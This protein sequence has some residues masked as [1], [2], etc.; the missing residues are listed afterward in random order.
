METSWKK[1]EI[2]FRIGFLSKLLTV[3][4]LFSSN[5]IAR[6]DCQK[7]FSEQVPN[8]NVAFDQVTSIW[9]D[10]HLTLVS[11]EVHPT[12]DYQSIGP[13]HQGNYRVFTHQIFSA[14]LFNVEVLD[15]TNILDHPITDNKFSSQ[16]YSKKAIKNGRHR[17]AQ[18][19]NEILDFV[20]PLYKERRGWSEE[21]ITHLRRKAHE[22]IDHTRYIVVRDKSGN[23]VATLGLSR[24]TYG[25]VK[26][27]NKITQ[28][29]EELTGPFGRRFSD[30]NYQGLYDN[31]YGVGYALPGLWGKPIPLL[32]METLFSEKAFLPRPS[33][34]EDL[35]PDLQQQFGAANTILKQRELFLRTDYRGTE[36]F[37]WK[38]P[39]GAEPDLDKLIEFSVG[40]IFEP[41][42]FAIA[43]DKELRQFAHK[44]ILL[45]LFAMIFSGRGSPIDEMQNQYLYT[46]NDEAGIAL[47]RRFGFE[48]L[49]NVKSQIVD[50]TR[51]FVLGLSPR[52]LSNFLLNHKNISEDEARNILESLQA[53]FS[54]SEPSNSELP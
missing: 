14:E 27:H 9:N 19:L 5:A 45:Q 28:K 11:R 3:S 30:D 37:I 48:K 39:K 23:I 26:F 29:V 18:L 12:V 15:S 34:R 44:E 33:T 20:L 31:T 40:Q 47:Y 8:F 22:S 7:L 46:Y 32:P 21:F 50:G 2:H 42:K 43:K 24:A 13:L 41:T 10:S 16:K 36:K 49:D 38:W 1:S 54:R 25:K 53:D 6:F 17:Q 52:R 4:L 51:W 35:E